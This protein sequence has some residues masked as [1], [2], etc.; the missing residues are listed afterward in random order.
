MRLPL[1]LCLSALLALPAAG[2]SSLSSPLP[3]ATPQPLEDN[4]S[5]QVT[6]EQAA[7]VKRGLA[8]LANHQSPS[9]G[10]A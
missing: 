9:G 1:A 4:A 10:W 3:S 7:A 6:A 8:W 5:V 2:R